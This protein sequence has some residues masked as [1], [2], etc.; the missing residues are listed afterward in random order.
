MIKETWQALLETEE[1][2]VFFRRWAKAFA[3]LSVIVVVF[4]LAT[5]AYRSYLGA[6]IEVFGIR[7]EGFPHPDSSTGY[8][9][10]RD[11]S[12][13]TRP[14]PLAWNTDAECVRDI[15][16]ALIA[17]QVADRETSGTV[18]Y[19]KTPNGWIMAWCWGEET[20]VGQSL[21]DVIAFGHNPSESDSAVDDFLAVV[22]NSAN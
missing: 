8:S 14:V 6:T 17:M 13:K 5:A 18:V 7:I 11:F 4:L 9:I 21:S 1:G 2:R 20:Q 15:H 12:F 3:S 16:Q 10:H 19:G 22:K